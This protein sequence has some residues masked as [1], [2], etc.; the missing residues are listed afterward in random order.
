V[1]Y[2]QLSWSLRKNPR[3]HLHE[4]TN[5]RYKGRERIPD[6][7]DFVTIDVSFISLKKVLLKVAEFMDKGGNIIALVKP[8]F[9]VG[10]G[11]VGKGGIVR[12]EV[13]RQAAV[14]SIRTFAEEKGFRTLGVFQSPLSGQKGNI[15]Y[16]LYLRKD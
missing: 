4:R 15:E 12:E 9:E 14:D 3:V 8:Q 16:F 11:E 6:V 5:I 7:I 1:G 13:K 10:K 2:G